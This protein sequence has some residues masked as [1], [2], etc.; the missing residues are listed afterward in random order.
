MFRACSTPAGGEKRF[1][2]WAWNSH[3]RL[4]LIPGTAAPMRRT[5][6]IKVLI[7]VWRDSMAVRENDHVVQTA[8]E[9]RAGATGHN[10]RMVLG[11]SLFGVAVLFAIVFLYF[12]H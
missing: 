1:R 3:R 5:T 10:V 9:A 8:T 11:L 7:K 2:L 12:F 4:A 6:S